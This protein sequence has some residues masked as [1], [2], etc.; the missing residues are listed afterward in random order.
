M[1]QIVV[2]KIQSCFMVLISTSISVSLCMLA[3][4]GSVNA[5]TPTSDGFLQYDNPVNGFKIKYPPD[6][7]PTEDNLVSNNTVVEFNAP[8]R[9]SFA[10]EVQKARSYLDTDTFTMKIENKTAKQY[11]MQDLDS[12]SHMLPE[13]NFRKI[14]D[15]EFIVAGQPAWKLE[16]GTSLYDL[17]LLYEFKVFTVA[18]G[19]L[20]TLKYSALDIN[21]PKTIPTANKMVE[22][23][24]IIS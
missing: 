22:S 2:C 7:Q 4:L 19:K 8:D 6:W 21:V 9:S 23:F 1:T 20:Y 15:N 17:G 11:A 10:V 16:Y 5:Q 12:L 24:Q 18:D 13:L 14:R 3:T